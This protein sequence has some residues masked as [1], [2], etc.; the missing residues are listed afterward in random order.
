[1]FVNP[2][3]VSRIEGIL[4]SRTMS[5]GRAPSGRFDM[6]R[7]INLISISELRVAPFVSGNI[8]IASSSLQVRGQISSTILLADST[9]TSGQNTA[10]SVN[11]VISEIKLSEVLEIS[12]QVAV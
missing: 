5:M 6:C 8:T 10:T 7:D 12:C 1:M 3:P 11:D 4:P 2:I 9:A